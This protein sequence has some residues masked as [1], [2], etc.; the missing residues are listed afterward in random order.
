[1]SYEKQFRDALFKKWDKEFDKG[2]KSFVDDVRAKNKVSNDRLLKIVEAIKGKDFVDELRGFLISID[3][4]FAYLQIARKPV[5]MRLKDDR[6]EL[7]PE[8]W[9]DQR[10]SN[11]YK[12]GGIGG[13]ICIQIKENRWL[14]FHFE[15]L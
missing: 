7:I 10:S 8:L 14:K 2:W 13:T 3:E 11:M 1:M 6:F 9:I 15:L 4:E 12:I 5:G